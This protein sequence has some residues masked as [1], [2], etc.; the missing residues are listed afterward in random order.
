ML[1]PQEKCK[2]ERGYPSSQLRWLNKVDHDTAERSEIQS[3]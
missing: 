2:I 1:F 3:A